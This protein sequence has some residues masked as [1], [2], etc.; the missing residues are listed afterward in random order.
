MIAIQPNRVASIRLPRSTQ[1]GHRQPSRRRTHEK[2]ASDCQPRRCL[3]RRRGSTQSNGLQEPARVKLMELVLFVKYITLL[4]T[5]GF[6]T[7]TSTKISKNHTQNT[8]LPKKDYIYIYITSV[9]PQLQPQPAQ[10]E[11]R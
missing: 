8:S 3:P 5:G 6:N 9:P 11:A 10:R 4:K 2:F 1:T 7:A